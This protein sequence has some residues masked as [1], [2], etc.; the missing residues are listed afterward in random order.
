MLIAGDGSMA[1]D[2]EVMCGLTV[3]RPTQVD[4]MKQ[5]PMYLRPVYN[6]HSQ[7]HTHLLQPISFQ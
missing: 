1:T 4:M 3:I 7:T 2:S 6:G 5:A